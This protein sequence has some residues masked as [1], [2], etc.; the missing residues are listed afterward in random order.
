MDRSTSRLALTGLAVLS[1]VATL[2][3]ARAAEPTPGSPEW[4]QRDAANMAYATQRQQ[5][6]WTNPAFGGTYWTTAAPVFVESWFDQARHPDRPAPGLSRLLPG[7]AA[8][9]YRRHWDGARGVASPVEYLNRCGARIQGTIFAPRVGAP[10]PIIEGRTLQ[11]PFGG[12]VIT[13]GSIQGYEEMYWWAAQGLAE[14]GYVVMTFDVMGQGESEWSCHG[15]GSSTG[16]DVGTLDALDFFLSD[17]N[18]QRGALDATRIGLAG[19]SA[20]GFAVTRLGNMPTLEIRPGVTIPNPVDAVV[21]WDSA[22]LGTVAPRV[23]TMSQNAEYFFNPTPATAQPAEG[24]RAWYTAMTAAGVPAFQLSLRGSTH[25][26]WTYVPYILPASRDGERV[27][28]HYTLAWF[29]RWV[30]GEGDPAVQA[31]ARARLVATAFDDSADASSI[32]AGT[33][34][35]GTNRNVPNMIGGEPVE[36]HLSVYYKTSF[37]FDGYTCEN[38]RI[39]PC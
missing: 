22:Q 29:D 16:F 37:A 30:K 25:L 10:D 27:A 26:E 24:K 34:D 4:M 31:D 28:M 15:G 13:T 7:E 2:G 3:P 5:D 6:M 8:D 17:A 32:G 38:A 20:G 18:P 14:A 1:V 12:V 21:A 23:P 36:G 33:W 39:D 9:P 35:A 11:P 19:H